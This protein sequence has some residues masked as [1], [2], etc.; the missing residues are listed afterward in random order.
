MRLE[1]MPDGRFAV[2]RF[3]PQYKIVRCQPT[4]LPKWV[5]SKAKCLA[6]CGMG[7]SVPEVGVRVTET[8]MYIDT[9]HR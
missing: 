4:Q 8:V 5:R 3:A 1:V 7:E 9:L 2:N 6:T